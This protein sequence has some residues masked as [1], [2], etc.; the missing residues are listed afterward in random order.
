[1]LKC[2]LL[3]EPFNFQLD[4]TAIRE[5]TGGASV[6][7]YTLFQTLLQPNA[8]PAL[9]NLGNDTFDVEVILFYVK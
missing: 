4:H 6:A 5:R 2:H 8:L 7:A 9:S 1:M 3:F